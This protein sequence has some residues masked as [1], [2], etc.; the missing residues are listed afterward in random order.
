MGTELVAVAGTGEGVGDC[1]G[2]DGSDGAAVAIASALV[3]SGT[4]D[5]ATRAATVP[6][7]A[8]SAGTS[9]GLE[10]ERLQASP[11]ATRAVAANPT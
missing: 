1:S 9:V 5:S 3:A 8:V 6:A 4:A 2:R 11:T 7:M 10:A